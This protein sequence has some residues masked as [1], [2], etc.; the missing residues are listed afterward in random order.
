MAT[1]VPKLIFQY[2]FKVQMVNLFVL[3]QRVYRAARLLLTAPTTLD[4]HMDYVYS[5]AFG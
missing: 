5:H 2:S 3:L 4:G 1:S